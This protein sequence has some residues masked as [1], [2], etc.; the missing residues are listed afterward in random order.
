MLTLTDQKKDVI[1]CL[2]EEIQDQQRQIFPDHAP[3]FN[4]S[5]RNKIRLMR[6]ILRIIDRYPEVAVKHLLYFIEC[7]IEGEKF[8][9]NFYNTVELSDPHFD[10]IDNLEHIR[11]LIRKAGKVKWESELTPS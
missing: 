4:N 6:Q 2:L 5:L 9:L 1:R 10:N 3:T 11:F 8:L 7:K